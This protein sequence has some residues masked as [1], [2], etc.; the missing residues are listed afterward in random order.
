MPQ[1]PD[2]KVHWDSQHKAREQEFRN[3]EMIPN[4]FAKR[5]LQF[6]PR[7]GLVLEIGA[8]NGRDARYFAKMK[9]TDVIA[10][11]ISI[12]AIRQLQEA[13]T[14]DN[15]TTKLV[16]F[17][18]DVRHIFDTFDIGESLDLFYSRSALHL[19]NQDLDNFFGQLN[20]NI[21][22]GGYIAIQGKP[23]NDFKLIKSRDLGDGTF[24]EENGHIRRAWSPDSIM[25]ICEKYGYELEFIEET[26]EEWQGK[27]TNFI[28]FVAK[29][30]WQK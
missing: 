20:K 6:I 14:R 27:E 13:S 19:N 26:T 28:G 23:L 11:D 21:K 4:V 12:E 30:I 25:E 8:A 5:I 7:N 16:P 15:T 22:K 10:N 24:I 18:A 1:T 3:L 9:D 29:K 2:Q 17:V